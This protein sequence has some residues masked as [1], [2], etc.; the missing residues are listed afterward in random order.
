MKFVRKLA[1]VLVFILL[2]AGLLRTAAAWSRAGHMTTAAVAYDVLM[3][4]NPQVAAKVIALLK[5]HPHYE[6]RW[7]R[8][9]EKVDPADRD[10]ALFM[11]AARWPDDIRSDPDY[12]HPA[13]HYIDVPYKPAG[14][15]DSV[16][17][18]PA[19]DPNIETAYR[20]N[21]EILKGNGTAAQKAVALCWIFHLTGDVHQP[22]H[23]VALFSTEYPA[24]KGDAGG[25][26][27]FIRVTDDSDTINLHKFWD[28]LIIGSED[29]RDVKKMAIELRNRFPRA[30]LDK[31]PHSVTPND[32]PKWVEESLELAKS[33]TYLDGKL[34]TSPMRDKA[35]V[36]PKEYVQ[37]SKKVGERRGT[38]AGYRM[39]DVM[40]SIFAN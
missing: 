20:E 31:D 37:N 27:A 14:Q 30:E 36:L 5:Q 2:C 9:L 18:A 25:T 16:E 22:L 17:T 1:V 10:Q 26:K 29:T 38:Q 28:D 32:L 34:A 8:Q 3:Q 15:P 23:S 35:P 11:L 24:P 21:V 19:P 13:W 6:R 4:E 40:V 33:A 12:D 39:A 7:A